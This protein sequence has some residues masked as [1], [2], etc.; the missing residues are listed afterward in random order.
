MPE[1]PDV[2][3]FREYVDATSLHKTVDAVAVDDGRELHRVSARSVATTLRG[4]TLEATVRHGK[5]LFIFL[6]A[7]APRWLRLHFGMTGSVRAWKAGRPDDVDHVRLLVTFADGW[8]LAYL[9]PRRFGEIGLVGDPR[10]SVRER[11]LGPDALDDE[12]DRGAFAD[13]FHGRR[14]G[15]KSALMDQSV[16]AGLGNVYVDEILFQ[17]EL[18]PKT[19]VAALDR[20]SLGRVHGVM[21]RVLK[22]AI[23]ARVDVG[24]MP[25]RWLL[26]RREAGRGCPRC[27]GTLQATNVAGRTTVLCPR[28]QQRVEV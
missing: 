18:H 27:D 3:V 1:L 10:E 23:E 21:R 20:R 5:H 8:R 2:Q 12:L 9:C 22:R 25:R 24:R 11:D 15:L 17:A 28:H 26:P 19:A 16:I 13:R 6:G 7:G 4:R 14:G